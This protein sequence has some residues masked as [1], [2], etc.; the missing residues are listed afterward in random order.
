MRMQ[1]FLSLLVLSLMLTACSSSKKLS[2]SV[3]EY[4]VHYYNNSQ[5]PACGEVYKDGVNLYG[6]GEMSGPEGQDE[7]LTRVASSK[8]TME[9]AQKAAGIQNKIQGRMGTFAKKITQEGGESG[10]WFSMQ[11]EVR[12]NSVEEVGSTCEAGDRGYV[13]YTLLKMPKT[14]IL[15]MASASLK[16]KDEDLY[17]QWVS[18]ESYQELLAELKK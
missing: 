10:N 14:A 4:A 3:S 15:E 2:C 8:A 18:S 6:F 5:N 11:F 12:L 9:I 7:M 13:C 1:S 17:Q 16:E